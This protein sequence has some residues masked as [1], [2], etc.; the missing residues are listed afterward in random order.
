MLNANQIDRQMAKPAA[1][2]AEAASLTASLSPARNRRIRVGCGIE[3]LTP[4]QRE[5][6]QLLAQGFYYKEIGAALGIS[7]CTVRA[8]L[9]SVY[10]RLEVKSRA[11]AVVKFNEH[12][13]LGRTNA[14]CL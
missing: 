1:L 13:S 3:R 4:R 7:H 9:H 14:A 8:H 5:I 12:L 10:Q 11:R 6:L 2:D